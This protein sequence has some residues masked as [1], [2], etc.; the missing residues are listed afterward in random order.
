M[1][2][3]VKATCQDGMVRIIACETKDLVNE[4][5]K[6]HNLMPTGAALL[7]RM[8]TAGVIMGSTLKNEKEALTLQIKGDG[9]AHATLVTAKGDGTIKG[10]I[11]NPN[12]DLPLKENGKLDISG[13]VGTNGSL[14]VI[15]DYGLKDPYVSSSPIVSG[16]I[17]EDF[18]YY[19]T[20]SEQTPSAVNLG[21][22][23]DTDYSIRSAGGY[24]IQMMPGAPEGL[25]DVITYRIAE[26]PPLTQLLSE[27]KTIVDVLNMLFDDMGLKI[28]ELESARYECNCSK[29]RM[30]KALIAIGK[31]D[32]TELYEDNQT[33][34][35]V[36]HF[37]NTSYK[38]SHDDIGKL[39][40]K[41]N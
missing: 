34:E 16:E 5:R 24:L 7:G 22:L 18:A 19:Y 9:P 32:L 21:V 2:R 31:K 23:V 13:A 4:A 41:T 8:L 36:C 35:I 33:E 15:V 26:I 40:E 3:L 27:G 14:T 12:I 29:E 1:D 30:E 39:L 11:N 25:A 20:V 6:I 37:C 17:A 10:Y 28:T 38:F